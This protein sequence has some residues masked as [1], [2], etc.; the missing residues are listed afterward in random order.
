MSK[1]EVVIILLPFCFLI[2]SVGCT[3]TLGIIPVQNEKSIRITFGSCKKLK[4]GPAKIFDSIGLENSDIFM[5]I[6]DAAYIRHF[7]Q[8]RDVYWDVPF[9][10]NKVDL[11]CK[12]TV[13]E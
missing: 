13:Q 9:K 11:K 8:W 10:S 7:D 4:Y 6:G 2:I 5:F 3:S 12:T 1:Y